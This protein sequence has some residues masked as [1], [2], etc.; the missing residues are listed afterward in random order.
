MGMA[1]MLDG[2]GPNVTLAEIGCRRVKE[3]MFYYRKYRSSVWNQDSG[4][5]VGD[6]FRHPSTS[7]LTRPHW[8]VWAASNLGLEEKSGERGTR[9]FLV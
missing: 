2:V 6:R 3:H 5:H 8:R 9:P 7:R 1:G 4:V